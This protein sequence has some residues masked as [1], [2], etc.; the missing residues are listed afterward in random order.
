MKKTT[1]LFFS[2]ILLLST[3]LP[4]MP[5]VEA[6]AISDVPASN[7][8]Y[9]AVN[10]A[11][12]NGLMSLDAG[13]KF[14]LNGNVSEADMLL[15]F[16]KLDANYTPSVTTEMAYL[17]YGDLNIPLKGVLSKAK[18]SGLATR[19]DFAVVYAAM[20][21]LDLSKVQAVQYLYTQEVAT[22]TSGKKTYEGYAP[23]RSLSQT[24]HI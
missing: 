24:T 14:N 6:A 4:Y 2:F 10:W 20:R 23:D 15:M 17:Y 16:A 1:V 18:R 3:W 19:S 8:K 22:G 5:E 7:A 12:E 21:G 11:V 13:K 9:T